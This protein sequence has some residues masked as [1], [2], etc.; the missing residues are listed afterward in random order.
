MIIIGTASWSIPRASAKAFPRAGTHLHRYAQTLRGVEINSSFYRPHAAATYARWAQQTPRNFSFAVKLPKHITHDARLRAARAPLREFLAGL[1]GLGRRLG[2]LLVQL[3]PSLSYEPRAAGRFFGLLRDLH[4]GPVVC[5]PRH[6][7]WF[8]ARADRL[9]VRHRIGRVAA[10]P[11]AVPAAALPGGW[12][13]LVYYRL[14]GSPRMYWSTYEPERLAQWTR[15]LKMQPRGIPVWCVFDNTAEGAAT[16][17]AL[18]LQ[19]ML[20]RRRPGSVSQARRTA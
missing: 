15:A 9:M 14:H 4:E 3:P 8:E 2:P 17:N 16:G 7:S 19:A 11:A 13:E 5:E 1:R 10:D 20:S 6:A 12:A 18:Q